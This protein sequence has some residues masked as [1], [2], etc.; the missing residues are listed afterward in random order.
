MSIPRMEQSR[1]LLCPRKH[2]PD[3]PSNAKGWFIQDKIAKDWFIADKLKLP[4]AVLTW[5]I[6]DKIAV[7]CIKITQIS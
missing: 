1:L 4:K 3:V 6:Q 5:F 2:E 7:G